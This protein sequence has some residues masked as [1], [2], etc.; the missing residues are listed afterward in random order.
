MIYLF[1]MIYS[2]LDGQVEI[3]EVFSAERFQRRVNDEKKRT[4]LDKVTRV[5]PPE[6][7]KVGLLKFSAGPLKAHDKK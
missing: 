1:S 2:I 4:I 7:N 3:F 5:Y 6:K